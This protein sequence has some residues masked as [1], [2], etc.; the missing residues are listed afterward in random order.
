VSPS[1]APAEEPVRPVVLVAHGG[2]IAAR[3]TAAFAAAT[4]RQT[5]PALGGHGQH[6]LDPAVR[7]QPPTSPS[8]A[9]DFDAIR[10]A[11]L[12]CGTASAQ[13]RRRCPLSDRPGPTLL[14]FR[15]LPCLLRAP[16]AGLTGRRPTDLAQHRLPHSS[17]GGTG[18]DRPDR[19]GRAGISGGRP[20]QDPRAWAALPR[21]G[22]GDLQRPGGDGLG[23]RRPLPHRNWRGAD[24]A[25][26]RPPWAAAMGSPMATV[27]CS[28]DCLRWPELLCPPHLSVEYPRNRRGGAIDFNRPR[29]PPLWHQLPSVAR[30]RDLWGKAPSTAGP[31]TVAAIHRVGRRNTTFPLG[32]LESRLVAEHVLSGRGN[33]R[34]EI[35]WNFEAHQAVAELMLKGPL[36]EAGIE[37]EKTGAAEFMPVVVVDRLIGAPLPEETASAVGDTVK[38]PPATFCSTATDLRE[39]PWTTFFPTDNIHEYGDGH[40]TAACDTGRVWPTSTGR[41][42]PTSGG[43]RGDRRAPVQG[44]LSGNAGCR[45]D[46]R[47]PSSVQ[48]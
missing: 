17:V 3:W 18:A 21:A 7:A 26:V 33:P 27:G 24:S 44:A 45:R 4:G 20:T 28:R 15:R 19:L 38:L 10:W 36:A 32:R 42:W 12:T 29:N 48:Q 35:H 23:C 2:L 8:G 39:W 6:Q 1:G 47:G 11:A 37:A 43:G 34:M 30:R 22:S 5:G 16:P 31:G 46:V 14:V 25:Y 9:D 40:P 41:R 13:G